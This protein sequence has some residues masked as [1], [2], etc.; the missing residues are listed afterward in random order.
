MIKAS[1]SD[2]ITLFFANSFN[3]DD[4]RR[5]YKGAYP[6]G[7]GQPYIWVREVWSDFLIVSREDVDGNVTKTVKVP[8][9]ID[10]AGKATFGE[11]KEVKQVY[12]L[13][14]APELTTKLTDAQL[15]KAALI[16]CTVKDRGKLTEMV[17]LSSRRKALDPALISFSA[18]KPNLSALLSR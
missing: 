12:A 1:N 8:F 2:E 4:I 17:A 5:Q 9:T 13:L 10:K 7:P 14:T 18:D 11:E 6:N 15:E 16:P 3:I